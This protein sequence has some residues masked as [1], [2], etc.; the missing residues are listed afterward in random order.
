[1]QAA[2][3]NAVIVRPAVMFGEDDAFLNAIVGLLRR[4]PAYPLLGRGLTRLQPVFVEDVAA[5]IARSLAPDALNPATYE[6]G[7]PRV[8]TYEALIREIA[9][10]LGKRPIL[11]SVP[12]TLWHLLARM[13][14]ACRTGFEERTAIA[15]PCGGAAKQG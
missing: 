8:Y 5:A 15:A 14:A 4:L 2:F 9:G 1:V 6:F 13:L 11:V 3:A 10:R 7:G 12:L